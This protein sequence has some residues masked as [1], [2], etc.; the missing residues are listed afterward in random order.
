ML[1]PLIPPSQGPAG[2]GN[3]PER[4]L[5]DQGFLGAAWGPE[6]RTQEAEA[7]DRRFPQCS[8]KPLV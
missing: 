1:G 3:G 8:A 5:L 4:L 7:A 2:L 6:Q